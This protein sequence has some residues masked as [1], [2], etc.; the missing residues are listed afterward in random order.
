VGLTGPACSKGTRKNQKPGKIRFGL[1]S[2]SRPAQASLENPLKEEKKN[3]LQN[4]VSLS[5]ALASVRLIPSAHVGV[6]SWLSP[7]VGGWRPFAA[8]SSRPRRFRRR[9]PFARYVPCS[10]YRISSPDR[11][12]APLFDFAPLFTQNPSSS[13]TV[14]EPKPVIIGGMV[15]DIHAKPSVPPQPS[16]T[17][18]GMVKHFSSCKLLF[19]T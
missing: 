12:G 2:I 4:G 18:P 1:P 19:W 15:L 17:V 11:D 14:L 13:P 9:P 5:S 3:S 16:T 6:V 8:T 7:P 10:P